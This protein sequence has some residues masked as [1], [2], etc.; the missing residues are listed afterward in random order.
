MKLLPPIGTKTFGAILGVM[1][2][3]A[4]ACTSAATPTPT[5][6]PTP[7]PASITG[8]GIEGGDPEFV[9]S[10]MVWQGYWL[11]RGHFGP[12]V[13]ASGM[14]VPVMPPPEMMQNAMQMVAQNPA[15]PVPS[16]QNMLPLQAVFASG[17]S[18]LINDPRDFDPLDL[19]GFR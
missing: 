14:G 2:L 15:D 8:S 13:M 4:V 19:Q 7:I 11:S 10:A 9:V 5:P 6:T 12:F 17:S 16:I 18:D 1:G 3:V